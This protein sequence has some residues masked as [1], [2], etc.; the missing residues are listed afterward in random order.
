MFKYWRFTV[1][2]KILNMLLR[3]NTKGLEENGYRKP[4]SKS[5]HKYTLRVFRQAGVKIAFFLFGG[6]FFWLGASDF[7]QVG[8][9]HARFYTKY[10][11]I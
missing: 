6:K 11:L 2:K 9:E 5:T 4:P 1:N 3:Q 10:L 8:N 7:I